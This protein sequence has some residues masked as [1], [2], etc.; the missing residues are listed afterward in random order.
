[1]S[2]LE[3]MTEEELDLLQRK[4]NKELNSVRGK[5]GKGEEIRDLRAQV[6]KV[7]AVKDK[8][9]QERYAE[10]EKLAVEGL[11]TE[12]RSEAAAAV[13]EAERLMGG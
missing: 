13:S 2:D 10:Y 6:L 12:V 9:Q 1:M 7:Q 8:K 11:S 5:P 4:M 3:N